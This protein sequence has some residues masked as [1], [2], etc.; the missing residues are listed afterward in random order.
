MKKIKLTLPAFVL[1]ALMMLGCG[2]GGG[3]G[4]GGNDAGGL[5]PPVT[6]QDNNKHKPA[7]NC[8]GRCTDPL[9]A[10]RIDISNKTGYNCVYNSNGCVKRSL[11]EISTFEAFDAAI[12]NSWEARGG[13][14]HGQDSISGQTGSAFF[15]YTADIDGKGT[16]KMPCLNAVDIAAAEAAANQKMAELHPVS[17]KA[18]NLE[19]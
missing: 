1:S 2:G 19:K 11:H 3:G 16:Y 12:M 8:P 7:T 4:G 14:Y 18:I 17:R 9:R 15:T 10:S 13:D 5:Y 6:P